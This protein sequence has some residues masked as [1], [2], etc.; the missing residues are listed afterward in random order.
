[1][2]I[3]LKAGLIAT[4]ALAA[5]VPAGLIVKAT[6][7][8]PVAEPVEALAATLVEPNAASVPA[9]AA[10]VATAAPAAVVPTAKLADAAPVADQPTSTLP[11]TTPPKATTRLS[12]AEAVD[13]IGRDGDLKRFGAPNVPAPRGTAAAATTSSQTGAAAME[14]PG[15]SSASDA[16]RVVR[17]ESIGSGAM[18]SAPIGAGASASVPETVEPV[19]RQQA[20][21]AAQRLRE[22][23]AMMDASKTDAAAQAKPLLPAGVARGPQIL[24]PAPDADGRAGPAVALPP[25][26]VD[27][28]LNPPTTPIGA[29]PAGADAKPGDGVKVAAADAKAPTSDAKADADPADPLHKLVAEEAD[30]N[31]VPVALATALVDV[32]SG[33]DP[34]KTSDEGRIGLMQIKY[35]TARNLGFRGKSEELKKPETNVKYGMKYLAAAYKRADKDTCKTV[36]KFMS[37]VYTEKLRDQHVA[38]CNKV[39]SRMP[40]ATG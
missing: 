32:E 34:K 3:P 16:P 37:G 40:E 6:S 20:L 11:K 24:P 9:N 4:A 33:F 7:H 29:A 30:A 23:F 1:M 13:A 22:T 8:R 28:A 39:K 17:T 2:P 31:G 5:L 36:M 25:P 38:T 35:E 10:A 21:A 26:A 19:D 18:G 27:L 14:V 15:S 12:A